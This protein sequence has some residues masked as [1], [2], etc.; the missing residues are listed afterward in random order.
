MKGRY[1][2]EKGTS[3]VMYH[4][5]TRIEALW[6]TAV[7]TFDEDG[8]ITTVEEKPREL[9]GQLAVPPFY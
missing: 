7:I 5:E 1:A 9:K 8:W 3:C 6:K 2:Q 4:K